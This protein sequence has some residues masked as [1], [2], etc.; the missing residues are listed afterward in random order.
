MA[1]LRH[2]DRTRGTGTEASPDLSRLPGRLFSVRFDRGSLRLDAPQTVE[3]PAY[4]RWDP[5]VR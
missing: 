4:L 3:V 1:H 5:A 2:K